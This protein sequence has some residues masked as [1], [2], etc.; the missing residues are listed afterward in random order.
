MKYLSYSDIVVNTICTIL[1][2]IDKLLLGNIVDVHSEGS[3][4]EEAGKAE[5]YS[6]MFFV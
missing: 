1:M 3:L 4:P 5:N 6:H 2:C